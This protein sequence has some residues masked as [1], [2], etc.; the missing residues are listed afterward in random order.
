MTIRGAIGM[1]DELEPNQVDYFN[2]VIWLSVLDQQVYTEILQT[3]EGMP[4][5]IEM[6]L[7]DYSTDVDTE[8]LIP[9]QYGAVVYSE[10]LRMKINEA[11]NETD[12]MSLAAQMFRDAYRRYA[13]WYN[14]THKPKSVGVWRF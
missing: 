7:Y 2:K 8:L 10:Y 6:P 3:H 5:D 1:A 14:R 13:D 4:E 12:R 9:D 11:V